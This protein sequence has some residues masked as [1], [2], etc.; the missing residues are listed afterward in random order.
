MIADTFTEFIKGL[1]VVEDYDEDSDTED[2]DIQLSDDL[3][4]MLKERD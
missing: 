1:C 3:I 2:I 4:K